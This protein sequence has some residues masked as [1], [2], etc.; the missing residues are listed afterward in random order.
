[1]KNTIS[2]LTKKMLLSIYGVN[3]LINL[4][5]GLNIDGSKIIEEI[6]YNK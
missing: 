3:A 2:T 1:M 5:V 6:N 4:K